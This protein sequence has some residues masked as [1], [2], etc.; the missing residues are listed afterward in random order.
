M[1]SPLEAAKYLAS[2]SGIDVG[3]VPSESPGVVDPETL[4]SLLDD[5]QVII[6]TW[7][8]LCPTKVRS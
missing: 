2:Q 6:L 3:E 8:K 1:T 5:I 4:G 7:E